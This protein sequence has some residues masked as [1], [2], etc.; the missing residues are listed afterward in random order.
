[1]SKIVQPE[2]LTRHPAAR[3]GEPGARGADPGLSAGR[4]TLGYYDLDL[5]I[6]VHAFVGG[7]P[8]YCREFAGGDTPAGLAFLSSLPAPI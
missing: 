2:S 3:M 4:A 7:T 8:A 5:A 1:V 6:R